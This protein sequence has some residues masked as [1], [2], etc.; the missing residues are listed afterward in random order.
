LFLTAAHALL[1]DRGL[2]QDPDL[3]GPWLA[4]WRG[5]YHGKALAMASPASTAEV[6]ALVKLCNEHNVPIV[7]QGGNSGMSGGATPDG[8]GTALLISLRRMNAITRL[9]A[10]GRQAVCEAGVILQTVH[11]AAEA[12]GLRFP[13]TLGGKGS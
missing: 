7:P 11:E 6:S 13:L 12:H 10:D 4:D 9:D 3:V 2:T 1:G 8:S 5:R